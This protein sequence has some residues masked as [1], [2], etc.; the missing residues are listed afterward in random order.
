MNAIDERDIRAQLDRAVAAIEPVAPPLDGLR[1]R[2]GRRRRIRQGGAGFMAVAAVAAIV[3]I[4]VVVLPGGGGKQTLKTATAPS[5]ASFVAFADARGGLKIVGP[6]EE[7][8]GFYGAFTTKAGIAI[9]TYRAHHWTQ[10]GPVVTSLG[11]GRYVNLLRFA[12]ALPAAGSRDPTPSVYLREIGGDVSYFG[13]FLRKVGNRWTT[14][15]FGSCGHHH[16]CA[17]AGNGEPYLHHGSAPGLVSI[18]NNCTPDCAAGTDYR[19]SWDWNP[20]QQ[21]FDAV[22]VTK[23]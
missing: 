11:S 9:A 18:Q 17:R 3:L 15:R 16:L 23:L 14:A 13:S 6:F 1:A 22:K 8:N 5:R 21:Q 20:S 10:S 12:P 2:A 7:S 4:A 19:V